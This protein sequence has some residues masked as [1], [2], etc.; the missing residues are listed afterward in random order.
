MT[1][2]I[3]KQRGALHRSPP[4]H[5]AAVQDTGVRSKDGFPKPRW[6]QIKIHRPQM[7]PEHLPICLIKRLEALGGEAATH[8]PLA[9]QTIRLNR[10]VADPLT[11]E[12]M[13]PK[14]SRTPPEDLSIPACTVPKIF[15]GEPLI[16]KDT[17]GKT[18]VLFKLLGDTI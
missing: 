13:Q 12:R 7:H 3:L 5:S 2:R 9:C 17:T 11:G 4:K 1:N 16:R 15:D 8:C 6:P 10:P 18:N 14:G